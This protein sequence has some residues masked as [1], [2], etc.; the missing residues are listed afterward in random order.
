VF[1]FISPPQAE[2]SRPASI[3][4]PTDSSLCI[5]TPF[6]AVQPSN[7]L[8]LLQ[9]GQ[10]ALEL[11]EGGLPQ[12]SNP[13]SSAYCR[14]ASSPARSPMS[15][16]RWSSTRQNFKDAHLAEVAEAEAGRAGPF[17][18]KLATPSITGAGDTVTGS[19][20]GG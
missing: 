20:S 3:S 1:P 17:P 10:A 2:S 19:S 18:A 11:A 16:R 4:S 6:A 13:C 15:P 5:S 8:D 12:V 9:G 7:A 14:R